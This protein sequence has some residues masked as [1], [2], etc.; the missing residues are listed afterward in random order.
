MTLAIG[1][2]QAKTVLQTSTSAVVNVKTVLIL[3]QKITAGAVGQ[4]LTTTPTKRPVPYATVYAPQDT[5]G[6]NG[7]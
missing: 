4:R 6:A 5:L 1:L 2:T 3:K 7:R